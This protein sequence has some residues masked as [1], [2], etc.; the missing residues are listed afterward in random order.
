MEENKKLIKYKKL[1]E[2]Y[3]KINSDEFNEL[4][5]YFFETQCQSYFEEI[6]KINKYKYTQK[7]CQELLLKVSLGYLKEAIKFLYEN[8]NNNEKN[9]LKL[10]AIAY[11]K[12]YCYYYVEI[13]YSY[14]DLCN[15]EE[16]NKILDDK[17]EENQKIRNMR[18]IY[19]W[20]L[21][22]KK[23]E[24]FDQFKSF[25]F[26]Q[27]N[28]P[29]YKELADILQKEEEG[30]KGYVFQNSFISQ[31]HKAYYNKILPQIEKFNSS[32]KNNL[33][34]NFEEVNENF[35]AFYCLIVN[36][37]ISC[38]YTNQ[39]EIMINKMKYIYDISNNKIQLNEEA[40]TLIIY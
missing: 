33:E 4:L 27:K 22:F 9:I 34:L 29:I 18:N 30:Q 2:I 15:F 23:F 26:P 39:K 3:N 16:I 6:L 19:I 35:D 13:N 21:Y 1:I 12:T 25:P 14:F 8:K 40:K 11:I 20:R 32:P 10:Y 5:L 7:T 38:L 31:K 24:N 37:N 28:I 17:D 36:K